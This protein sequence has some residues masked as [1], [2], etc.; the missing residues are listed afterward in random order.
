MLDKIGTLSLAPSSLC[1]AI[2]KSPAGP[3]PWVAITPYMPDTL[4]RIQ[5]MFVYFLQ[6]PATNKRQLGHYMVKIALRV[7]DSVVRCC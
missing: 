3:E 2:Y 6:A 7:V 1:T 5:K 4:K